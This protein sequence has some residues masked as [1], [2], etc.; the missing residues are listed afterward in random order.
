MIWSSSE[1][2]GAIFRWCRR[3]LVTV[4]FPALHAAQFYWAFYLLILDF[5]IVPVQ[6]SEVFAAARHDGVLDCGAV[7]VLFGVLR[8]DHPV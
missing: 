2:V 7:A 5:G 1:W 6:T 3:V 8:A 4:F